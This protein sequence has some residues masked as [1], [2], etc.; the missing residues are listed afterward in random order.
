[1]TA[2]T[3][4]ELSTMSAA[5]SLTLIAGDSDLRGI[6]PGMATAQGS[7]YVRAF[8]APDPPGSRQPWP[9]DT[10]ASRSAQTSRKSS[11]TPPAP[12]SPTRS[13]PHTR[14]NTAKTAASSPTP[15]PRLPPWRSFLADRRHLKTEP[16]YQWVTPGS[17]LWSASV[18][19]RTPV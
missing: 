19:R 9:T 15:R 17:P 7:L 10:A 8:R 6:K 12:H 13:T 16:A 14:R 5:D 1:V 18:R 11:S 4:E 3:P 2:W